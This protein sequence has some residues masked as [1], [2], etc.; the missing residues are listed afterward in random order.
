LIIF[1]INNRFEERICVVEDPIKEENNSLFRNILIKKGI[2]T[3]SEL[4][5]IERDIEVTYDDYEKECEFVDIRHIQNILTSW[6]I[7][8]SKNILA[9]FGYPNLEMHHFKN[10]ENEL[11]IICID[12]TLEEIREVGLFSLETDFKR[13]ELIK[14]TQLD[15][16]LN[17]LQLENIPVNQYVWNF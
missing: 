15:P 1:F 11:F 16:F 6:N 9:E 13:L 2:A 4:Q 5:D 8:K 12:F 10:T 17:L 7:I 3:N 14:K